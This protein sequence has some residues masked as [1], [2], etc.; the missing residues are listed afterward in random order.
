MEYS[1]LLNK[2][3][4]GYRMAMEEA[5]EL[6]LKIIMGEVPEVVVAA[7]LTAL[8]MRGEDVEEIL[9]FSNAMRMCAIRVPLE[10]AVDIVGTGGDGYGTLNVSTATAILTSVLHPVAKHGNRAVSGRSGSADVLEAF[11]YRIDVEP[12]RAVELVNKTNFVFLFA[13]LYHPAMKNV[14]PVRKALG[15]RTVFNILGPLTNPGSTRRQVIGVFSKRYAEIVAEAVSRMDFEK[16]IVIHGEPG[17]DEASP[18]G[19][20]YVYEVK[21]GKVEH[22]TVVPED[23]GAPRVPIKNLAVSCAEDSAIRIIRASKGLDKDAE[24]FIRINTAFALNLIGAV[25]DLRDGYDYAGQLL[26]MFVDRM[27]QLVKLNGDVKRFELLKAK[28]L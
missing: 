3:V 6:A 27:E 12:G 17:I 25:K 10:H 9:G 16:V 1:R 21:R 14:M 8:R 24:V 26:A 20:T 28:A 15:I 2:L 22:Y 13:P 4:E 23:F 5:R 18:E 7:V 19:K 11:G